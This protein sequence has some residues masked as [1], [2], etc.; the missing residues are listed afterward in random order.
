[1]RRPPQRAKSTVVV[2]ASAR[3]AGER[4]LAVAPARGLWPR[5]LIS[6]MSSMCLAC[7]VTGWVTERGGSATPEIER[8]VSPDLELEV[9]CGYWW[10]V[11]GCVLLM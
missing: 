1:M 10:R 5:P 8:S 6:A 4:R 11:R 2:V 7:F 3:V 9:K